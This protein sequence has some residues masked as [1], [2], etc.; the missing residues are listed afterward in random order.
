MVAI[1]H[2]N[3]K[4]AALA[5]SCGASLISKR[6]I[7][8]AAHCIESQRGIRL[9]PADILVSLGRYDI[10]DFAESAQTISVQTAIVHPDYMKKS[11]SFDAD[12]GILVLSSSVSYSHSVR[13]ICLWKDTD[14]TDIVGLNGTVVGWGKT[15]TGELSSTPKIVN[16]PIVSDVECI[17][18]D[19]GFVFSTSERTFCAGGKAIG[20]CQGDSGGALMLKRNGRWFVR[21]IVSNALTN[22]N[23]GLCDLNKFVVFTDA[24][25]FSDWIMK[26]MY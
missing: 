26:Y 3:K 1:Y 2:L 20:P 9:L 23:T 13:P 21:G 12:L 5:F 10:F 8:T 25:K 4:L 15:E 24:S 22:P 17:R 14:K 16:V 19:P 18:S 6:T 7:L 11:D